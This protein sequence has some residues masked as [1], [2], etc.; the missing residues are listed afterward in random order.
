MLPAFQ[1]IFTSVALMRFT[2]PAVRVIVEELADER[3]PLPRTTERLPFTQ[4]IRL[5]GI[6]FDYGTGQPALTGID[7]TIPVN[8]TIGLAGR[9]GSGK[10]TLAGLILGVLSPGAGR[11]TVDGRALDP[12]TL[13]AWQNR[14]GYVPQEVF[15]VDGTVAE[16]I[17]LG[18][19]APDR[20]AVERAA[21]L[22]G[23]HDF[24]AALPQGYDARVGERGRG[25]RAA[26]AS[27]SASP[28]RSTTTPT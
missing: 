1:N 19:D 13:P 3:A 27:A 28:G 15:L 25:S 23:A 11:I 18:L 16:N 7:L 17:A 14:I 2:L 21:R 6:G 22:A 20:A 5:E 10:S 4:A 9:T 26:S 24:I 12:G 8:T